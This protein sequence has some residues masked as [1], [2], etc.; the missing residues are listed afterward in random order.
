MILI[1]PFVFSK[2]FDLFSNFFDFSFFF[3]ISSTGD[4]LFRLLLYSL[5]LQPDVFL[6]IN[7]IL[8]FILDPLKILELVYSLVDLLGQSILLSLLLLL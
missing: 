5:L 2:I 1:P 4:I 7:L 6:F 8:L 3:N